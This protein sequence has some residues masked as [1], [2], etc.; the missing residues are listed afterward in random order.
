MGPIMFYIAVQ[1]YG[2]GWSDV[3][4][5]L[6]R[7]LVCGVLSVGTAWLIA[8]GIGSSGQGR[9]DYVIQ[10]SIICVMSVALN[11]FLARLWMRPVWDDLWLRLRRMLPQRAAV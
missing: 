5:V 11:A 7:P 10:F 9:L 4:D 3:A 8:N 1:S 6:M 2:G